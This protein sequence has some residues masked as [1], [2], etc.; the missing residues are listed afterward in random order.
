VTA[1]DRRSDLL[2]TLREMVATLDAPHADVAA[3]IRGVADELESAPPGPV[4]ERLLRPVRRLRQGTMGSLS[5]VV[6]AELHDRRWVIDQERT[7]R[8]DRLSRRLAEDVAGLPPAQPPDLF[9]VTDRVREC[10]LD[11]P[12]LPAPPPWR[13]EVFPPVWLDRVAT[14]EVVSLVPE[15]GGPI[16]DDG[17]GVSIVWEG[18]SEG[19]GR[20]LGTGQVYSTRAAAEAGL[21]AEG[22]AGG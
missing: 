12:G 5:D 1:D 8:W 11:G 15:R 14:A 9:L 22:R 20:A 3:R 21:D 13:V 6:F 7:E 10:W 17:L 16:A 2:A 19:G 18:G 4:A